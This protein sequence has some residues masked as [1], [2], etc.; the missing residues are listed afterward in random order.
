MAEINQNED[1][2]D[3][4]VF[5]TSVDEMEYGIIESLMNAYNI[6]CV[7]RHKGAGQYVS[8]YMGV[9]KFGVDVLVPKRLLEQAQEL[10]KSNMAEESEDGG[11]QADD[12]LA[13]EN[14][15]VHT[16]G[17]RVMGWVLLLMFGLPSV[18]GAIAFIIY[19]LSDR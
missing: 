6:P 7:K 12:E 18:V 19:L 1:I 2:S 11:L 16:I 3:E 9:S 14:S 10:L 15:R 17:K 13:E 4:L 8:V 5:L